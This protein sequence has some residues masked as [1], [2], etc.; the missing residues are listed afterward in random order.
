[1]YF[2]ILYYNE[3]HIFCQ[4]HKQNDEENYLNLLQIL[5]FSVQLDIYNP[6]S[7]FNLGIGTLMIFTFPISVRF[8]KELLFRFRFFFGFFL[9]L[10]KWKIRF[11]FRNSSVKKIWLCFYFKKYYNILVVSISINYVR[12]ITIFSQI[13]YQLFRTKEKTN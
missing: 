12:K 13:S 5:F 2:L 3:V 7:C 11:L 1:L 9:V 4:I 8:L 6:Q 10:K